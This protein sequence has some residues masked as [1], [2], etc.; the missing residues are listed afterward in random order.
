MILYSV[1][2]RRDALPQPAKGP[3]LI[4][5][6]DRLVPDPEG[7]S[8]LF[9]VDYY[10]EAVDPATKSGSGIEYASS[11]VYRMDPRDAS[12]PERWEIPALEKSAKGGQDGQVVRYVRIPEFVGAAG[13]E[14]FFLT[15]DDDGK[16]YF[17][18]FDRGSRDAAR[19]SIDIA[20]DELF[21]TAYFISSEGILC[22]L[23]G[24]KYEARMVW[25]RFDKLLRAPSAGSRK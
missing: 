11:W 12:Y 2:L 8:I 6:L 10:R 13:T 15:A 4:A 7:R 17:S 20:P 25:W 23:L 24:T 3:S 5:S 1:R 22:A 9:K 14:L 16:T 21:Y 19:Y 18:A